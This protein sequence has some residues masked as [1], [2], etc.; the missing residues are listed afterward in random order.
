MAKSG[1]QN[2]ST[3]RMMAFKAWGTGSI[4]VRVIFKI[5]APGDLSGMG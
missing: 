5:K 2:V 3:A 4:N 1:Q